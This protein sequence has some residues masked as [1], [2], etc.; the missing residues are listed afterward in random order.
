MIKLDF[1]KLR[2]KPFTFKTPEKEILADDFEKLRLQNKLLVI[3]ARTSKEFDKFRILHSYNFPIE[4]NKEREIIGTLFKEKN[5]ITA[6]EKG[7]DLLIP[8]IDKYLDEIDEFLKQNLKN[9]KLVVYCS[10]GGLRS[11]ILSNLLELL[12]YE[13][14]RLIGGFK[15]YKHV[16]TK[17]LTEEVEKY[18]GKFLIIEGLTGTRKT[19]LL[20]KSKLPFLDLEGCA[21]HK[22]SVFGDVG[23]TPNSQKMFVA[24]LYEQFLELKN[25]KLILVEGEANRIGNV[26]VPLVI[27]DKM[28]KAKRIT[29][30]AS[31][32]TR[33]KATIKDYCNT[34]FKVNQIIEKLGKLSNYIGQNKRQELT[35]QFKNNEFQPAIQW[36]LTEYYDKKYRFANNK[37][38]ISICTDDLDVAI[39]ELN[40][41]Y[42]KFN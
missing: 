37:N 25:H 15:A 9:R 21:Q 3:D 27:W 11:G 22:A 35:T 36:L 30:T 40:E 33:V 7:W 12:G 29:V 28:Q 13:P 17:Y 24:K 41:V 34:E 4:N 32:K 39:K 42:E 6:I 1:D 18:K 31:V 20:Q 16:L 26:F 8:R 38:K 19:E 5:R 2:S 14:H 10:R 23:L